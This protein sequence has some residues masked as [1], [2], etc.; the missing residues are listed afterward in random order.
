[1][2]D[3]EGMTVEPLTLFEAVCHHAGCHWRQ[4]HPDEE[5][6]RQDAASHDREWHG[7]YA[8]TNEEAAIEW[9]AKMAR[10]VVAVRKV[11]NGPVAGFHPTH[12]GGCIG[13]LSQ[14]SC[15]C[16]LGDLRFAMMALDGDKL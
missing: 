4:T 5:S 7:R 9:E 16:G 11:V 1:M 15:E 6:A 14:P 13:V 10:L 8:L 12:L 3:K 2:A